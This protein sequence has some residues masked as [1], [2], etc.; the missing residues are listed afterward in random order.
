ML[1]PWRYQLEAIDATLTASA[2]ENSVCPSVCPRALTERCCGAYPL[3][4]T[5]SARAATPGPYTATAARADH[6]SQLVRSLDL[7]HDVALE[8]DLLPGSVRAQVLT[9]YTTV[10]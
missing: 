8:A 4:T 7:L 5:G 1:T 3:H 6:E 10:T 2:Q 9:A